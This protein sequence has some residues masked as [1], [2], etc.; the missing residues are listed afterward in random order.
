MLVHK[1]RDWAKVLFKTL[2]ELSGLQHAH[3]LL[4][5]FKKSGVITLKFS[6]NVS[7]A[8]T[9]LSLVLFSFSGADSTVVEMT[10]M[11]GVYSFNA[12]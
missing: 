11:S 5:R 12:R 10:K 1:T 8:A 4:Q 7:M 9:T 6:T 2:G 3:T